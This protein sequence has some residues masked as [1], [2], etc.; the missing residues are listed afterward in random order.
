M[1]LSLA[2]AGST[3]WFATLRLRTYLHAFQ[4]E[5]Y[6][7]PRLLRWW[8][9][10]RAF[11]RWATLG[12]LVAAPFGVLQPHAPAF[13]TFFWLIWR[14]RQEPDP[15]QHGKKPLVLTHRATKI[16]L[17]ASLLFLPFTLLLMAPTVKTTL[18]I[19]ILIQVLPLFLIAA[20]AL[21]WP[22][23]AL[24]NRRYL[25]EAKSILTQLN[26]TIIGLTG[27]FGKT[28]TK[29]ILNHILAGQAPTLATPGSVNTPLGIARVV[30]EQ[31]QPHHAYF[32]AEMG[33]YGPGSIARLCRL[34]PPKIS[35]I[36][37]LGPAHYE[38]FKSL[39]TV[40]AAK[41]EIAAATH[42]QGGICVLS[43]DAMPDNLWRPY[44]HVN[45]GG[46]RL[47]TARQ[48]FVRPGDYYIEEAH[49]TSKGLALTISRNGIT[50][51]FQT[52][53]FGEA[54]IGN[55]A[56]AFAVAVELGAKPATLAAAMASAQ[57]APHRLNIQQSGSQTIIDDSYNSNPTGFRTALRT[58]S[59]IAGVT[60]KAKKTARR[61]ILITPGMVELGAIHTEEHAKLGQI[62][63][64]NADV[65]LAV[66][67]ARIP[68][69][70]HAV[71]AAWGMAGKSQNLPTGGH[72][73]QNAEGKILAE[74]PTLAAA[75]TWMQAHGQ[76]D[77][78]VLIANDLPDRYEARWT[79]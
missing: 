10:K 71:Q 61:R 64:L 5:E 65:I 2:L 62:A 32:L 76:P 7:P 56:T 21:L 73:W 4:Q 58:L 30:R 39:E 54:Q 69:F 70:V 68:S 3:A 44:V 67:S 15:T 13:A 41:F 23:Q 40:A 42:A 43:I 26:P 11:D 66:A 9:E 77:D 63:A 59:L 45:P 18:F 29:Y 16:W 14:G 34:A 6:D 8:M 37:A 20:N 19:V 72:Q 51:S 36:T 22:I 60:P 55:L 75:R 35:C 48:E 49:E 74:V 17:L 78:A 25:K 50:S 53:I 38:R 12:I 33:A 28:S 47:V 79:L 1:L 27:S 57:P 52:P 31:L 24:Q 46:Y